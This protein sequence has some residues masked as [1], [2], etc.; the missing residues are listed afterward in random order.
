MSIEVD[1]DVPGCGLPMTMPG[2]VAF[3]PP[4]W[5]NA[6]HTRVTKYNICALCWAT[7]FCKLLNDGEL[8]ND[9]AQWPH[10][11]NAY[12][13]DTEYAKIVGPPAIPLIPDKK[14]KTIAPTDIGLKLLWKKDPAVEEMPENVD[15]MALI[16]RALREKIENNFKIY[17]QPK[18]NQFIKQFSYTDEE[19]VEIMMQQDWWHKK[20]KTHPIWDLIKRGWL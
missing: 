8:E 15:V 12:P 3:S 10:V 4:I 18:N 19:L 5:H 11:R 14:M 16:S 9:V 7:K 13:N 6:K 2:A 1:C 17:T 20:E